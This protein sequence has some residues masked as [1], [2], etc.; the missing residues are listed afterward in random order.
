M[1][2]PYG[3]AASG[4]PPEM[5]AEAMGLSKREAIMQALLQ[6]SQAPFDIQ[7]NGGRFATPA[8]PMQGIAKIAQALFAAQGSR[9]S[10]K[11]IA[12]FAAKRQNMTSDALKA[13]EL[14][15]SG[16]PAEPIPYGA[17]MSGDDEGNPMPPVMKDAVPGNAR[18]A[19]AQALSNP[20]LASNPLVQQDLKKIEPDWKVHEQ[21]DSSGRKTQVLVNLNNPTET[22]PF[23]GTEKAHLVPVEKAGPDGRPVTVFV[24]PNATPD[25][26]P[27]PVKK[28][29]VDLGG[30]KVAVDEY[31]PPAELT[32][33]VTPDARYSR[34]TTYTT[35]G[36]GADGLPTGDIKEVAKAIA[37]NRMAPLS[38]F[39]MASPRGQMIM[40]EV[41]KINPSYDVKDY[42]AADKA[43]KDFTTG[44][45]GNTVRSFNVALAH[46]DT[47]DKAADALQNGDV[48]AF[49]KVGNYIAEQTGQP[50]PTEFGAIKKI[51]GDEI[52]KA[53]VGSGGGVEDRRE[54]AETLA[55]AN[56]PQQLKGVIKQYKEL[57]RGQLGG[58]R[59][60]YEQSTNRKDFDRFLSPEGLKTA[61][62]APSANKSVLEQ[63]DAILSGGK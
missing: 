7:Q 42:H 13:Y 24:D 59:Q 9:D 21:F 44:K 57:M 61:V 46:L 8:T 32:K 6:Q 51:V 10:A 52:V 23:G 37:E 62:G 58:L 55:K 50:A 36:L 30:K 41:T 18:A 1:S 22:R 63:A 26:I 12:D 38:S 17:G 49:N 33:T 31:N 5:V 25:A 43:V 20:M 11:G 15:K 2:D 4:L 54:A 40:S 48:Q 60:Q 14:A 3:L 45:Q 39:A 16:T 28:T 47:L 56:S 27:K 19:I 34:E 29:M 53:I 35:H